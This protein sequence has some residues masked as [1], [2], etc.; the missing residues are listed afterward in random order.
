MGIFSHNQ[1]TSSDPDL[2]RLL[3]VHLAANIRVVPL[4]WVPLWRVRC[5]V[6]SGTARVTACLGDN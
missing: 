5:N 6:L 4:C 1:L 2:S 3:Y